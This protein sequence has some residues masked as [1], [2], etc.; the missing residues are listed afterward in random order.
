MRV[1][2]DSRAPFVTDKQK[3][4]STMSGSVDSRSGRSPPARWPAPPKRN[5]GRTQVKGLFDRHTAPSRGCRPEAQRVVLPAF[6]DTRGSRH[7]Q[8]PDLHHRSGRFYVI[9]QRQ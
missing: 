2:A 7:L 9:K 8:A 5:A 1:V 4:E 6:C 3:E